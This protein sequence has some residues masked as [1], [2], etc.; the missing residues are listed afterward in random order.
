MLSTIGSSAWAQNSENLTCADVPNK[1]II[2]AKFKPDT[3]A[4]PV[5]AYYAGGYVGPIGSPAGPPTG[6][7]PANSWFASTIPLCGQYPYQ[8]HIGIYTPPGPWVPYQG[9]SSNLAG[10]SIPVNRLEEQ[11]CAVGN[12][13]YVGSGLKQQQETDFVGTTSP[14]LTLK[15]LY[16]SSYLVAPADGFGALWMHEWQ[17]RLDLSRY[18]GAT[19]SLT[20]LRADGTSTTFALSNGI[21]TSTDHKSDQVAVVSD[22]GGAVPGFRLTDRRNDRTEDYDATGKLLLVKAHNGWTTSVKYSD[23]STPTTVAPYANLLIE[24][25]N[26]F[27]QTIRF[28]YD[29]SGRIN[30][31]T[32]PDGTIVQY[33]YDPYGMLITVTHADNSQRKYHYENSQYRWALTGIT[34]EKGIRFATYGY[35]SL[36]RATST[37]HAG[38]VDK[39]QLSFLGNGQTSVT[40]A[41]GTSRT[42]TSELQGNVLRATGASAS[43]AACGDIAKEV[44]YDAAGNVASKRD[45]ADKETRYSYDGLG[46][47]TQRIEG[48]GTAD[49]KTTTTEWHPTWD[50]PLRVAAPG[51]A[52]NFTYDAKGQLIAHAWFPTNDVNGSQGLN[53]IP[54]GPVASTGWTYD[55]NGLVTATVEKVGDGVTAQRA[56]TYDALGNLATVTNGKGKIGTALRYD[57]AGR[58]LEG[59][60]VNGVRSIYTYNQRGLLTAIDSDAYHIRYEYDAIGQRTAVIGPGDW[61]TT[62][63]YDTAHRLVQILDNL[64]VTA[65]SGEGGAGLNPFARESE[66]SSISQSISTLWNTVIVWLRDWVA[67]FI[68]AAQAQTVPAGS[69][70]INPPLHTG[71]GQPTSPAGI[72]GAE[73]DPTLTA[74]DLRPGM[75]LIQAVVTPI[76]QACAA[77]SEAV[78]AGLDAIRKAFDPREKCNSTVVRDQAMAAAYAWAGI[79]PTG[80]GATPFPWNNFNLPRGMSRNDKAYGD[81]MRRYYPPSYGYGTPDGAEVVEHPFG[82]PDLPGPEHHACPHFHATNAAGQTKIFAYRFDQ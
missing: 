31:A 14:H 62:Y 22:A 19:P 59:V 16:R 3:I 69:T 12:P 47:E 70:Q 24:V 29:G 57:G 80:E 52:D 77:S 48:Y 78:Q 20:A 79:S 42:F 11:S 51:L 1:K 23:T 66:A 71:L 44:T 50:L 38:G 40:T 61:I 27:A 63:T 21:W 53:A 4:P 9:S 25:R 56:F 35:D 8:Y 36:G 60:D 15:R 32:M 45:F 55:A 33:G 7:I 37:E 17:R 18:Y 39:Y 10:T 81:F 74:K 67:S 75:L 43:C 34:D 54:D 6:S 28:A 5:L 13:C 49:A 82:H 68:P 64:T 58:L 46:R 41:D 30:A 26:Q 73:L 72:P 2:R 76:A 65:D